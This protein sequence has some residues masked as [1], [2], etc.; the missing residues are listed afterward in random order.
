MKVYEVGEQGKPAK[1]SFICAGTFWDDGK[2]YL[3][4]VFCQSAF[5]RIRQKSLCIVKRCPA[6]TGKVFFY[7]YTCTCTT[8]KYYVYI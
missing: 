3:F 6:N 1:I 7:A 4:G 2:R 8:Y 5:D